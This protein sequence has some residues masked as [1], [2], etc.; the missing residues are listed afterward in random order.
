[1]IGWGLEFAVDS[2]LITLRLEVHFRRGI[3]LTWT[4]FDAHEETRERERFYRPTQVVA[5]A[6]ELD[7]RFRRAQ[8]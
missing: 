4:L 2:L 1:V 6:L 5:S 8:A 7:E 3:F